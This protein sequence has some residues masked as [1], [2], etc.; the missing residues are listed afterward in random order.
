MQGVYISR[1]FS[2]ILGNDEMRLYFWF[3][4]WIKLDCGQSLGSLRRNKACEITKGTCVTGAVKEKRRGES[5]TRTCAQSEGNAE[6]SPSSPST[7]YTVGPSS[8]KVLDLFGHRTRK[9]SLIKE[10]AGSASHDP[11][12]LKEFG[13]SFHYDV[14][15]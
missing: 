12:G 14:T 4:T 9:H 3:D 15:Y 10:N 7:G 11:R 6:D 13:L 5:H 2:L 8:P 1:T